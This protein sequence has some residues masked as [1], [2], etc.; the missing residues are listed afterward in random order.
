M[1]TFTPVISTQTFTGSNGDFLGANWGWLRDTG[2]GSYA[3]IYGNK[4]AGHF[5]EASA[6]D[7]TTQTHVAVHRWVGA[8]TFSDDQY[9][10]AVISAIFLSG[11]PQY[12]AGVIVRAS[13]GTDAAATFYCAYFCDNGTVVIGKPSGAGL[14]LT[15]LDSRSQTF[16]DGD[17]FTLGVEGAAT[18]VLT[19]Y[20]NGTATTSTVSDSS[21]PLT[22]GKPGVYC[23]SDDSGGSPFPVLDDWIAGDYTTSGGGVSNQLSWIRA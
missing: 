1:P 2:F 14:A 20:K 8:G 6:A 11:S 17:V 23:A 13:G 3:N 15:I 22:T 7:T 9:A 12:R 21:S 5:A 18:A 16:V 4:L 19:V 10:S